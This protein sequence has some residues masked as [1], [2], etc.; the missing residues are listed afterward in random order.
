MRKNIPEN[1]GKGRR[2][3]LTISDFDT[4]FKNFIIPFLTQK[5]YN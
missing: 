1:A 3:L 5:L 2:N 4:F